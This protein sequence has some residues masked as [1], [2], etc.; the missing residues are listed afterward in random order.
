MDPDL[1]FGTRLHRH[2]ST[3]TS[4]FIKNIPGK[5]RSG[6]SAGMLHAF[7]VAPNVVL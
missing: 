6:T 5:A 1:Y 7:R 3:W 2:L 4:I